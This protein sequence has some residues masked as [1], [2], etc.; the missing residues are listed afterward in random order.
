MLNSVKTCCFTGHRAIERNVIPALQDELR[1][2]IES[3]YHRGYT[4]FISGGAIGFDLLAAVTV[5]NFK[6]IQP[7]VTL[8]LALPCLGHFRKWGEH[9]IRLFHRVLERSNDVVYLSREYYNGC[10]MARNRYMVDN[11]NVCVAYL[12]QTS[13]GG[14]VA[15]VRFAQQKG[16]EIINLYDKINHIKSDFII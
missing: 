12:S 16:I 8:V 14:T 9:D 7:D 1:D 3:L 13:K 11:S 2:A 4:N 5:L 10:T 6:S 15:T